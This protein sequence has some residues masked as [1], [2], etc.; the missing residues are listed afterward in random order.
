MATGEKW[1]TSGEGSQ[2][3][4]EARFTSHINPGKGTTPATEKKRAL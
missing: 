1:P 4:Q 3:R 2:P